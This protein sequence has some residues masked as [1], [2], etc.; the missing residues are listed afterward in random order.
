M[1]DL[2]NL[3]SKAI[4]AS[5]W[6]IF[7]KFSLQIVQFVVGVVLARLLEPS[8]YG[9]IAITTIF[10]SISGA[11][12][13]GGFEKTL[14]REKNLTDI[15]IDSV[16]FLNT[17]L[18]IGITALLFFSAPSLAVFFHEP[19]LTPV[20]RA[21]SFGPLINALGQTQRVLL[22]KE[23]HFRKISVAQ[24]IASTSAGFTGILL[25]FLGFGVWS[26]VWSG[27]LGQVVLLFFFWYRSDWYPRLRFSLTSIRHML[28]YGINILATSILFFVMMQFNN[29]II[30]KKF[31][32]ADLGLYNR[33]GRL[34]DFVMSVIQSV[35]LKMAFPLFAKVQDEHGQLKHV[36]R[37]TTQAVAFI[38][39]PLLALMIVNAR[40]ITIVL[41]TAKWSGSIIFMELFC[42]ITLFEPF[43]AVY[44]ELILVKGNSR[45][46]LHIFLITST[47][48]ILLVLLLARFGI[49]Y[50]V[51]ATITGR[52]AQY[53]TYLSYTSRKYRLNWKEQLG[54]IK[55]YFLIALVTAAGVKALDFVLPLAGWPL[56]VTVAIKLGAG[57]G[58]YCLLAR[59]ARLDELSFLK[60]LYQ[61]FGKKMQWAGGYAMRRL[62][63]HRHIQLK[64][65]DREP[66]PF[67]MG[68][69]CGAK[70]IGY[71]NA[72]LIS[73]YRSWDKL[74]EILVISDGTPVETFRQ[75][76]IKWPR[77][78]DIISWEEVSR[79]FEQNP[80]L[81]FYANNFIFG[82]KF[83]ALLWLGQESPSLYCDTDIL[84][85]SSPEEPQIHTNPFLKMSRDIDK[86]FYDLEVIRTL[87]EERC[88]ESAPLNS[89]LMYLSGDFSSYP[90]WRELCKAL[91]IDRSGKGR[92]DFSE[93]TAWAILNNHFNPQSWWGLEEVL[94][95]VDDMHNLE[96]TGNHFPSI[97]ARHY[98]N[99][100][101]TAFWRDF[102]YMC[103]LKKRKTSIARIPANVIVTKQIT[104]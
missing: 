41:L 20:L 2:Q 52:A 3:R 88:L 63:L 53:L 67:K 89:G 55:P 4:A 60:T 44:R 32:S 18:G 7:E 95:K 11:I 66:F 33:G 39:F 103:F 48:E 79:R 30:G 64:D 69:F 22:M 76:M 56:A 43:V 38:S 36:L 10:T 16:F 87:G 31:D 61:L 24:I 80:D 75:Q 96:F 19:M 21:V 25:A 93:Q 8:S 81:T 102:L 49:V 34:P 68:Y 47:A 73:I 78:L 26:L 5:A 57:I 17:F 62:N 54:W 97:R 15:Q 71:L 94:I 9:I 14:I 23:L 70:G 12:T 104:G 46:F 82:R 72:S 50:I 28:R 84:W 29:F 40:D 1:A 101:P 58:L 65:D 83:L 74:P 59:M 85:Y 35:V 27:L 45:L 77:R 92:I 91:A 37:K 90:N 42:L 86:G 100:K 51:L 99:T 98:V 6:A 13:D